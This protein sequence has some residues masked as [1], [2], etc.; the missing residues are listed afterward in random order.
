MRGLVYRSYEQT[1]MIQYRVYGNIGNLGW[2]ALCGTHT[3]WQ[4][5]GFH[6]YSRFQRGGTHW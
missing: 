2:E 5:D 3:K 1:T 6:C 4:T